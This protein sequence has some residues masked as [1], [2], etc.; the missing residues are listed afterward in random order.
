MLQTTS[1]HFSSARRAASE[2]PHALHEAHRP[3]LVV[4]EQHEADEDVPHAARDRVAAVEHAARVAADLGSQPD[5]HRGRDLV[6]AAEIVST[7][8]TTP[9]MF[10]I[11]TSN[12]FAVLGKKNVKKTYLAAAICGLVK[13]PAYDLFAVTP[14]ADGAAAAREGRGGGREG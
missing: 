8:D 11:S 6:G 7:N 12:R 1:T 2:V 13:K 14:T 5:S 9:G 4:L 3:V 10:M